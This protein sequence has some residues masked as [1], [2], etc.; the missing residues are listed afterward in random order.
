M[1]DRHLA[2]PLAAFA[3]VDTAPVFICVIRLRLS[4]SATH[5]LYQK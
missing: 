1:I 3:S 5:G 4:G 2:C